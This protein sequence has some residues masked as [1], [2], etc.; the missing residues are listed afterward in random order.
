MA[1][2]QLLLILSE[3]MTVEKKS[4]KAVITFLSRLRNHFVRIKPRPFFFPTPSDCEAEQLV[5]L[6]KTLYKINTLEK[7][8][9]NQPVNKVTVSN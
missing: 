1:Q 3:R 9:K 7:E 4:Q 2:Q 6:Q 5:T 8:Y